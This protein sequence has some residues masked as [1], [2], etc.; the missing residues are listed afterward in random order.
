MDQLKISNIRSASAKYAG[1]LDLREEILRKPLGISLR[2]EDLS[3]DHD[4]EIFIAE[5]GN[6]IVGCLLLH[7]YDTG[8]V[9][10]RAMAVANDWQGKGTGRSLVQVAE[11]YCVLNGIHKI[12]LHARKVAMGFYT[13]LG[14]TAYG[15][16]FVEV[17][18]PHY[19]M[20]KQLIE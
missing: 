1:V 6:R 16:E 4:D 3:R 2:N 20:E 19:L 8:V 18:I 12:I 11:Q 15:D 9:Q 13:S 10:L 14:Y 5:S 17:G 7:P